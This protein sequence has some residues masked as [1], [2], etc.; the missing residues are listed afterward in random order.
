[1]ADKKKDGESKGMSDEM[2]AEMAAETAADEA[3]T[4]SR[5]LGVGIVA[6]LCALAVIVFLG[7]RFE[8]C[9]YVDGSRPG[10]ALGK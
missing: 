3:W 8:G 10:P 6:F 5:L 9:V 2:A 4:G 7:S 1:M